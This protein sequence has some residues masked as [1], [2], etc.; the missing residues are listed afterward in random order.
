VKKSCYILLLLFLLC[1]CHRTA[2]QGPSKRSGM[3]Q[4]ADTTLLSLMEINQRLAEQADIELM[5][6]VDSLQK[7]DGSE[8]AQ[9]STG[10][11]KKRRDP[12]AREAAQY[13]DFPKPP[14]HWLVRIR[15]Y[16]LQGDLLKDVEG[17]YTIK[18][19]D[20]PIAV[21]EAVDEMCEGETATIYA[22]WY[23]AYGVKGDKTVKPYT[24]VRFE[25]TLKEKQ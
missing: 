1:G 18:H 24:N 22:P 25:V 16:S 21:E 8:F 4:K 2:P 12:Q 7:A 3:K 10:G 17:V 14:E 5:A 13:A 9:L 11:W 20:M 19:F 15:A 6:L 23:T